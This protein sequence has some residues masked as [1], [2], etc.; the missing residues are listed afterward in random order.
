MT[1]IQIQ[2]IY[3]IAPA[4]T[5]HTHTPTYVLDDGFSFFSAFFN[6]EFSVRIDSEI[7]ITEEEHKKNEL[8]KLKNK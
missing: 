1:I 5:P 8:V 7:I 3:T 2:E 4:H 6:V